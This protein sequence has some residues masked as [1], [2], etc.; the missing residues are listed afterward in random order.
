[1]QR[2]TILAFGAEAEVAGK[3]AIQLE[4]VALAQPSSVSGVAAVGDLH[5]LNRHIASGLCVVIVQSRNL[6]RR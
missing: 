5:Y 1:M 6:A 2:S 3:I 4:A